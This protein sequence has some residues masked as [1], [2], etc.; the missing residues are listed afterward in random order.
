MSPNLDPRDKSWLRQTG[1]KLPGLRTLYTQFLGFWATLKSVQLG[2]TSRI[3]QACSCSC[4]RALPQ[5]E[6]VFKLGK[7]A[8]SHPP[9]IPT[10]PSQGKEGEW[11]GWGGGRARSLLVN[12][13]CLP[14]WSCS[15]GF[16]FSLPSPSVLPHKLCSMVSIPP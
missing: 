14:R 10:K 15:P 3:P 9:V 4:W 6:V 8:S 2:K 13:S 7:E 16:D 5:Q 12:Q 1:L 11:E